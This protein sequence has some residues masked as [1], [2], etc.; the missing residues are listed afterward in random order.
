MKTNIDKDE[1]MHPRSLTAGTRPTR[2]G[3]EVGG[4]DDVHV[5]DDLG[6]DDDREEDGD[7]EDEEE[8]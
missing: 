8:R 1:C 2:L 5:D 4:D 3:K 7:Q 6:V